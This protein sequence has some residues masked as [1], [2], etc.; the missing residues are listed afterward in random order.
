MK[1]K[2]EA[3]VKFDDLPNHEV[4]A[5]PGPTLAKMTQELIFCETDVWALSSFETDKIKRK[6]IQTSFAG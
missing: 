4:T 1:K 2:E 5:S 6:S 3:G